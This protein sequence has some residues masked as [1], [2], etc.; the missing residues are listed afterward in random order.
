MNVKKQP[1]VVAIS[2]GIGGAKMALGLL[3]IL[4]P[5]RLS[6]VVNTGDDFEHL[7][8]RISPDLD[9]TLY[10]L[11]DLANPQTGW[12]R[13]N[14]TWSFLH[15]LEQM[16]G[17]TWFK[18]GDGDLALHLLRTRRLTGGESL[19][20]ITA[21][22]ARQLGVA[23]QILPMSDALVQTRVA[24][25]FG[26]L[27]FQ[28]YFVR[29]QC[30][31]RVNA[32]R[33]AGAE[34]AQVTPQVRAVLQDPQLDAIVICP[35]N[36]YLSIDPILAVPGMR[37]LLRDAAAPVIAI[38]PLIGGAAVKGPTAKIMGELGVPV[39]SLAVAQHYAG[40]I[41]GFVL[42]VH[43]RA[44]ETQL[45]LP[46]LITDTLMKSL[47]DRLRLARMTLDFAATL[48]RPRKTAA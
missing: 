26:E 43:D 23:A 44:M 40:L 39:S 5:Q 41:D 17:E 48:G 6:V 24:T 3:H 15:A 9:T 31:P 13:R 35:S 11:A 2:G 14:E 45:E 32:L 18:L 34:S 10:T 29:R 36:P 47:D 8:L 38:A 1:H 7:G 12:G 46:T 33:F 22:L 28:D 4:P 19:T 21:D 42:D 16:G 30:Q 37:E 27:E 20:Q 25:E